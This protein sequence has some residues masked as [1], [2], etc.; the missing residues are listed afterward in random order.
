MFFYQ[1]FRFLFCFLVSFFTFTIL[2]FFFVDFEIVL[3]K[4]YDTKSLQ[5]EI[6]NYK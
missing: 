5:K 2:S 4:K 3:G 6:G 1:F